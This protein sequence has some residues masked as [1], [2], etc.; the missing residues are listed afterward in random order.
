MSVALPCTALEAETVE[1]QRSFVMPT[2][3]GLPEPR[4]LRRPDEQ[5]RTAIAEAARQQETVQAEMLDGVGR[6]NM[7][8][9]KQIFVL[10]SSCR[11]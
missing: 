8:Q 10:L 9:S 3:R 6:E 5:T 2:W 4:P 1:L 11:T 7:G